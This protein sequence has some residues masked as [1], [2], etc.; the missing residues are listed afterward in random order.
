[1]TS[2]LTA[3]LAPVRHHR[4]LA[5]FSETASGSRPSEEERTRRVTMKPF[6]LMAG[7]GLIALLILIKLLKS[8]GL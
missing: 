2:K 3:Y 5:Y 7:L 4:D 8:L 1:M 6:L